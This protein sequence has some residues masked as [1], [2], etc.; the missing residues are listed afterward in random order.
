MVVSPQRYLVLARRVYTDAL[1]VQGILEKDSERDPGASARERFG[2]E[3]VEL[4]LAPEPAVHWV[5]RHEP[6]APSAA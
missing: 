2:T 1:T 4:V 5:F 6:A 3:W